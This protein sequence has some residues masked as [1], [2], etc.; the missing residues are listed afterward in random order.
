MFLSFLFFLQKFF[1]KNESKLK[2]KKNPDG[3]NHQNGFVRLP[4]KNVTFD[5]S[6]FE[7]CE[8]GD[9]SQK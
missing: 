3:D 1:R 2:K 4:W 6:D 9:P 7:L 8:G 5:I